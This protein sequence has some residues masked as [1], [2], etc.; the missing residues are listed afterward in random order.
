MQDKHNIK[1]SIKT[2]RKYIMVGSD[3][4][5]Q[6]PRLLAHYSQDETMINFPANPNSKK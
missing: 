6:E 1:K 2:R 5:Q 3:Y 4:S